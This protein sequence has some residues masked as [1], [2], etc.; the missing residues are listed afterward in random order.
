MQRTF[1]TVATV[2]LLGALM[3]C[4][5]LSGPPKVPAQQVRMAAPV[6]PDGWSAAEAGY[7]QGQA[8]HDIGQWALATLHYEQVLAMAPRHVGALN[9]LG[10]IHAQAGRT[11]AALALFARAVALAPGAPYLYNNAGYALL[12]AERLD[13]AGAQLRRAQQLDPASLQTQHNLVLWAQATR[14][15]GETPAGEVVQASTSGTRL[16]AVA[17]Q[18]YEL[19]VAEP[20]QAVQLAQAAQPV[21]FFAPRQPAGGRL[22]AKRG[23]GV[24]LARLLPAPG[25][26]PPGPSWPYRQMKTERQLAAGWEAL[27]KAPPTLLHLAVTATARRPGAA[28]DAQL[29]LVLAQAL[30]YGPRPKSGPAT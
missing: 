13:E 9:A 18:I 10:V 28:Q 5:Q 24:T 1:Q 25:I 27:A 21:P 12:R 11:D 20:R 8:A 16:V 15:A 3:A 22:A 6:L 4:A 2:S 19:R 14:G 23:A 7:L 30:H 29:R 26:S 17:P